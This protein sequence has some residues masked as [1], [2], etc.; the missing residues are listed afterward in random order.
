MSDAGDLLGDAL[1]AAIDA[2]AV[3]SPTRE[4]LFRALGAA[5]A[6]KTGAKGANVASAST[7]T[8]GDA[9][10]FYITG[11]TAIKYITTNGRAAGEK[12]T[13]QFD[14]SVTVTHYAATVPDGTAAIL[15]AGAANFSA[16]VNDTLTLVYDGAYWRE[17]CRTVI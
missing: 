11:I 7:I 3:G 10:Y 17:C 6:S 8:L 5:I 1:M 12:V 13:L 4:Q 2:I 16:T 9:T 14:A 15:L